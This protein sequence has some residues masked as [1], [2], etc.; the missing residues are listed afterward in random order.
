MSVNLSAS[1]PAAPAGNTNVTW[2]ADGEGNISGYVPDATSIELQTNGVDNASQTKLNLKNGTNITVSNSGADVTIDG[3]SSLPPSGSA[4]GDL[5]GSY[6]NPTVAKVNGGSVPASQPFVG[7]NSS[8]QIVAATAGALPNGTT[9]TTQTQ[10]DGSTKVATDAYVDTGLA[11]KQSTLTGTGIA[12]NTGACTELSGDAT[13]SGS[14]AVTVVKVNGASVPVSA[15]ALGSNGSSQL[16]DN[17]SLV[18][19]KSE[20]DAASGYAGLDSGTMLKLAEMKL[21]RNLQTGTSYTVADADRAKVVQFNNAAAIAVTLPQAGASSTFIDGW[22]C[23]LKN[24]GTG[25]ATVTPTT[26][27]I[28]GATVM[29]MPPGASALIFSDGSNYTL[30]NSGVMTTNNYF[31]SAGSQQWSGAGSG[32]AGVV[33]GNDVN[34]V[35]FN[36]FQPQIIKHISAKCSLGASGVTGAFGLCDHLGNKL[37]SSGSQSM[38]T[39]NTQY[40]ITLSGTWLL[41]PGTYRFVWTLSNTTATFFPFSA[42]NIGSSLTA[43]QNANFIKFFKASSAASGGDIP[44]SLGTFTA[45]GVAMTSGIPFVAFES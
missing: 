19:L 41:L 24:I 27:T 3:P 5:S 37:F 11:T 22:W 12:R 20:K 33:T 34:G 43:I 7:T 16:V 36:L 13:T 42:W 26:S 44:S 29:V 17:T 32:G 8:S 31:F 10:G 23:Y 25:V 1:T 21:G 39:T 6:P 40:F 35:L 2:Q 4:G 18:Q 30:V 45:S 9:A 28:D 14:N 15:T 38:T